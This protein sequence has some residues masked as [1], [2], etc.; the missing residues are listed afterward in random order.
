MDEDVLVSSLTQEELEEL[1][2][3]IETEEGGDDKC[4]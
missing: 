4:K 1:L 3:V 2:K